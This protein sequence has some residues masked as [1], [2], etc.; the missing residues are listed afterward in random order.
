M[1]L[2]TTRARALPSMPLSFHHNFWLHTAVST[3][4]TIPPQCWPR[5]P[6]CT[7]THV[8]T[9]MCTM[10]QADGTAVSDTYPDAVAMKAFSP[11]CPFPSQ[12][13]LLMHMH[14]CKEKQHMPASKNGALVCWH[15][16]AWGWP[17]QIKGFTAHLVRRYWLIR[18]IMGT[19]KL[20]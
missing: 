8:F 6:N 9:G 12:P 7:A 11:S 2:P 16:H 5:R 19:T 4:K 18:G 15:I 3:S 13:E 1:G 17:I 14:T 20:E 10:C